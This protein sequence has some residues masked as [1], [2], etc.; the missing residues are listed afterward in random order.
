MTATLQDNIAAAQ[1]LEQR[2]AWEGAVRAYEAALAE[3]P[4]LAEAH[5]N[6][7]NLLRR[8]GR[9]QDALAGYDRALALR[10]R[11]AAAHLNRGA[12]L[13]EQGQASEAIA[14][15]R[16]ATRIEPNNN[17]AWS[18]LGNALSGL[19]RHQEAIAA[20]RTAL[21]LAPDSAVG[22]FNLGNAL[23]AA[24]KPAEAAQSYMAALVQEPCMVE[25]AVNLSARLRQ[26][27]QPEA[28]LQAAQVAVNAAAALPQAHMALGTAHYDMGH[29][30]AAEQAL[31]AALALHPGWALGLANLGLV[32]SAQGR[33]DE[34]LVAYDSAI[35][36]AP[37][38]KQ[39][40]FGRATCLLAMGDFARGWPAFAVRSQ[41]P[42]A[43]RRDLRQ[44]VWQGE[45]AAGRTLLVHAE[46]GFGD[47]LQFVRFVPLAAA[48]SG[49]QVILEVQPELVRLLKDLPGITRAMPRGAKLKPFD[50]HVPMLDLP[51]LF[52]PDLAALA[53]ASPYVAADPVLLAANPLPPAPGRLRVGLVWAGQ[54]R[55]D[56]PHAFAMDRRR[57]LKLQDFAPL[58]PLCRDGAISLVSLQ[59][60]K[61][62]DQLKAPP[63]GLSIIDG[64]AGVSDFA[65]TAAIVA[66]LDLVIAVDTSTAHLAAAMGKQVWL[67][68]RFDACWRW[69]HGRSDSPWYPTLTLF[70]QERPNDWRGPIEAICARLSDRKTLL[71]WRKEAKDF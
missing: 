29:F 14:A 1:E 34:A 44:P 46:Q 63:P 5:F 56:Q 40:L 9:H 67:L 4:E 49:A 59:H 25:A 37:D 13:A 51:G 60:G 54:S 35:A 64:L 69:L 47:T 57:S 2:G 16:Q 15:Y 24:G 41:M 61:P 20:L 38:E 48:R 45:A 42:E 3:L 28:A 68:S 17:R 66:Q 10:P 70:R 62:A 43:R 65:D 12:L 26:M 58:A 30:A 52:A 21:R 53:P 6:R 7:A 31:R 11:W 36:R 33:L 39:A 32:L 27:G 8:A 50:V 23:S 22:L 18:N 55:P 71:F 19:E